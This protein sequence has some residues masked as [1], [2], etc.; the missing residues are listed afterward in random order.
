VWCVVVSL[1]CSGC[2][3]TSTNVCHKGDQNEGEFG[4]AH[5]AIAFRETEEGSAGRR[6]M[7]LSVRV[8]ACPTVTLAKYETS[9][10]TK[11]SRANKIAFN[12]SS[13]SLA[14]SVC[15]E[16]SA[17]EVKGIQRVHGVSIK[18]PQKRYGSAVQ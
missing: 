4:S 7:Q 11:F 2:A 3:R 17:R 10:G 15:W 1:L 8:C 5:H 12:Q 9:S 18:R 13:F 6:K 16:G 14:F